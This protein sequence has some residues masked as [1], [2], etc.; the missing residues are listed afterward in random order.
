[1]ADF[2]WDDYATDAPAGSFNWDDHPIEA[3]QV[4]KGDSALRGAAQGVSLGFG[5]E[6][7]GLAGALAGKSGIKFP[8]VGKVP[9]KGYEY[10][11]DYARQH[12]KDAAIAN[13]KTFG[14][15]ELAGSIGPALVPGLN[16]AGAGLGGTA[17]RV[18]LQGALM[19]AGN[20]ENDLTSAS[21]LKD[22]AI[23][24]GVGAL[25]GAAG[26]GLS[27]ALPAGINATKGL[28]SGA[29]DSLDNTAENL[30]IKATGATGKQSE[31]FADDTGRQLLDR[32]IVKFGDSPEKIAARAA[33]AQLNSGENIGNALSALDQKGVKVS[34]QKV[35]DNLQNQV[36]E[37][38][39]IPGNEKIIGQLK[40]QI[41]NLSQR[42]EQDLPVSLAEK[43]KR[44]Y[45]NQVNYNSPKVDQDAT[46][47][48]AS[49][50]RGEVENAASAADPEVGKHFIEDKKLY[51]AL[52]PVRV[53]AEKRANQL[54]QSPFGG[55]GDLA[56][57]GLTPGGA[58]VKAATI[59]ARRFIAP[60]A[61]SSLAV[62]AYK[63]SDVLRATPEVLG[64]FAPVLQQA[65]QRGSQGLAATHFILQQTQ[66]EYQELIRNMDGT[67]RQQD[68]Q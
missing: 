60:R 8:Y 59:A 12:D 7:T 1:M 52:D 66:P 11:R 68:A 25:G 29:A 34:Y 26:Y 24:G 35:I 54:N 15:S 48:I 47:K 45:Q 10:Y 32:G 41:E 31:K 23:G 46:A 17:A 67:N 36:E 21:G 49:A 61:S 3:P 58:P 56:A 14:A 16:A 64:K 42:S 39:K 6:L 53:A 43:A 37:L 30:A 33:E 40:S 22:V 5:D 19:G 13:P 20:T 38:D 28:F 9:D 50:F 27:K 57:A 2:K 44:N 62:G 63:L 65:A 4:S 51:G 55:F 18:G